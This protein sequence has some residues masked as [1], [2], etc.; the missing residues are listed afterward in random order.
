MAL[1]SQVDANTG[2]IHINAAEEGGGGISALPLNKNTLIHFKT[3]S[4]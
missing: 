4:E 1:F 3:C 2:R